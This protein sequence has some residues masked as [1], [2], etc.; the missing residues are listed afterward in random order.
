[1]SK[2]QIKRGKQKWRNKPG[3]L[4]YTGDVASSKV[5]VE[6]IAYN[7]DSGDIAYGEKVSEYE[8]FGGFRWIDIRGLNNKAVMAEIGDTLGLDDLLLE[9]IMHMGERPRAELQKGYLF[10]I[11]KNLSLDKEKIRIKQEQISFV[12]KDNTIISFQDSDSEVIRYAKEKFE[13]PKHSLRRKGIDYTL[14]YIMDLI[15]DNY[16]LIVSDI[17]EK[18]EEIE[19][20]I[21]GA[22]GK[23]NIEEVYRIRKELLLLR[24]SIWPLDDIM[25]SMIREETMVTDSTKE[26]MRD[27]KGNISQIIDY[28][29]I[30][31]ESILGLFDIYLSNTSN[32]MNRIMQTLTII[33][34]MF[35]PSTFLAG[36]YGMNFKIFPELEARFAYP[37]FWIVNI[38]L[39][40]FMYNYFKNKR[41]I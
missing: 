8:N 39:M 40:V 17:E 20:S 9:D 10:L 6:V 41:W 23:M 4:M 22:D 2:T 11:M 34:I 16:F 19:E 27:L 13:N 26:Y 14:Y 33:S 35:I 15:V 25:H 32:R 7:T 1:M 31:R 29:S 5:N 37:V 12:I 18:I 30:Y 3:E 21:I 38:V 28:T 36:V 24:A